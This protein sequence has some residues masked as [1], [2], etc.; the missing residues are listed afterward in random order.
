MVIDPPNVI[1]F[2]SQKYFSVSM[3]VGHNNYDSIQR[4]SKCLEAL[5]RIEK[6][7]EPFINFVRAGSSVA[8]PARTLITTTARRRYFSI[9][10]LPHSA[11]RFRRRAV[12]LAF[13]QRSSR[14]APVHAKLGGGF[15]I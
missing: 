14:A 7:N 15:F 2:S 8:L 6:S 11:V 1:C 5:R 13:R 3:V 10:F 12:T 4:V 9:R